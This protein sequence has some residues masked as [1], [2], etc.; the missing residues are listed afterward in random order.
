MTT[1]EYAFLLIFSVACGGCVRAAVLAWSGRTKRS[2]ATQT[3]VAVT[4]ILLANL[5]P[6]GMVWMGAPGSFLFRRATL[7]ADIVLGVA[8]GSVIHAVAFRPFFRDPWTGATIGP[9][10]WTVFAFGTGIF[11]EVIWRGFA[12]AHGVALFGRPGGLLAL[13]LFAFGHMARG[14]PGLLG[15]AVLGFGCAALLDLRGSL[16]APVVAHITY[17][18][19]IGCVGGRDGAH[20][21]SGLMQTIS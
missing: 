8:L 10:W 1:S 15:P 12:Y 16:V 9:W 5:L 13:A 19:L 20:S 3:R 21:R 17:N 18:L 7:P 2:P 4:A 6:F 11:E 14:L